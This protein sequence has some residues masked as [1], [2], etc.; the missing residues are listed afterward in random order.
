MLPLASLAS[1]TV[2]VQMSRGD[3]CNF[4]TVVTL[5]VGVDMPGGLACRYVQLV[6]GG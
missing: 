1:S 3:G 4:L 6:Y 2:H 5:I